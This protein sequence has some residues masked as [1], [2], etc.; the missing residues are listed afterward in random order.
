LTTSAPAPRPVKVLAIVGSLRRGSYNKALLKEAIAVKPLEMEVTEFDLR[1]LPFFDGDVEAVGDPQPVSELKAAV[2][3][4][5]ALLIVS[6]EYNHSIPG[7][8]KNAIDWAARNPQKGVAF[9]AMAGKPVGIMGTGGAAGTARAQLHLRQVLA[10]TRSYVM[11]QP[12]I[13]VT[14]ARQKFDPNFKLTDDPTRVQLTD[15]MRAL[16]DWARRMKAA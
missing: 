6:P 14:F 9:A 2:T 15:F 8:L 11:V 13:V 4:A 5:D 16:A 3:A 1:P 10:E 12:T 7:L